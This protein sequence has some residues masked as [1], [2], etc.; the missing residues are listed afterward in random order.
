[1][2]EEIDK[3]FVDENQTTDS[4]LLVSVLENFVQLTTSGTIHFLPN[5]MKLGTT[6]KILVVLLAKK[7]M[8]MKISG[9]NESTSPKEVQQLTGLSVGSTNPSLRALAEKRLVIS[10]N[11]AY[12][13]PAFAMPSVKELLDRDLK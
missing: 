5:F 12:N 13:I 2:V 7:A 1:M 11:G 8:A 6:S 3:L 9:Y 10:N 4:V